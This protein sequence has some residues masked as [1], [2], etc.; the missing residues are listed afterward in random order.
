[1]LKT[2][3]NNTTLK[4]RSIKKASLILGLAF[5]IATSLTQ[6]EGMAQDFEQI[7]ELTKAQGTICYFSPS[8]GDPGGFNKWKEFIEKN[9]KFPYVP[10]PGRAATILG[11]KVLANGIIDSVKVIRSSNQEIDAE[12]V[13]LLKLSS[14]WKPAM[15]ENKAISCRMSI[16]IIPY[17]SKKD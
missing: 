16:R 12:S 9:S 6:N 3:R 13:R 14:P 11:F 7:E 8:A 4:G 1:M 10:N 15:F 17:H 5:F 2:V